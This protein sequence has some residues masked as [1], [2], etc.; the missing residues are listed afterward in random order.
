MH[1]DNVSNI[2][3]GLYRSPSFVK[4][5]L[6]KVGVPQR[7][8]SSEDRRMPA[9]LPENCIAEEFE[10]G[11]IVWSAFYHAPAEIVK[12]APDRQF[13]MDTYSSRCYQTYIFEKTSNDNDYYLPSGS[14]GFYAWNAAYDLGKLSH[15]AEIGIDIRKEIYDQ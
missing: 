10:V 14:A 5:I 4:N 7:P 15:L 1:G 6:D 13:Y 11:E 8:S 2:A 12:E 3:K 9:F